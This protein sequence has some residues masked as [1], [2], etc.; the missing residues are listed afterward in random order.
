MHCVS[1][2]GGAPGYPLRLAPAAGRARL[3][4]LPGAAS[5]ARRLT[6]GSARLALAMAA[7]GTSQSSS[8]HSG[9]SPASPAGGWVAYA[10]TAVVVE[11]LSNSVTQ[12]QAFIRLQA[13][14]AAGQLD[15]QSGSAPHACAAAASGAVPGAAEGAHASA[16]RFQR[17]G[18][19]GA[20]LLHLR[21][22]SP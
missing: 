13:R 5:L 14:P 12:L 22:A 19:G 11:M 16:H 20:H 4:G 15:G 6:T 21:R 1:L 8:D 17:E 2:T 18:V 9:A 7:V 3:A 10:K